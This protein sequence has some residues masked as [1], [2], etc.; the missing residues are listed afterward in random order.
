MPLSTSFD[1]FGGIDFFRI[2]GP[3]R[4]FGDSRAA[5]GFSEGPRLADELPSRLGGGFPKDFNGFP[6]DLKGS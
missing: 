2:F 3:R 5:G 1:D 6:K 4:S